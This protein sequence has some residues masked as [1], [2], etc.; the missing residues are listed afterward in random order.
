MNQ[1]SVKLLR[2]DLINIIH[3]IFETRLLFVGSAPLLNNHYEHR[4]H[5]NENKTSF[6]INRVQ[7]N[8]H[9]SND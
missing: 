5:L 7:C 9:E 2:L 3:L 1:M 4:G 8:R 6:W